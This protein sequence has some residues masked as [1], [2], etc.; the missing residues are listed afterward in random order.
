ME[1]RMNKQELINLIGNRDV[2]CKKTQNTFIAE[3][4]WN[5]KYH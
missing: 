3:S 1:K 2:M 4:K 5:S